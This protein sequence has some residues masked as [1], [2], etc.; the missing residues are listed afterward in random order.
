MPHDAPS[1][2]R[3]MVSRFGIIPGV[4]IPIWFT[5][6]RLITDTAGTLSLILAVSAAPVLI[7]LYLATWWIP[8]RR[9]HWLSSRSTALLLTSWTLGLSFGLTVPDLGEGAA[10]VLV[11]LAGEDVVGISAAISNPS[12]VL[13][14][15]TA[16]LA[17]G[18]CLADTRR[19]RPSGTAQEF[20]DDS[21]LHTFGYTFLH[22]QAS[23]HQENSDPHMRT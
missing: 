2:L 18:F 8:R 21:M 10:S 19:T 7:G 4:G 1:P 3:R 14:T 5:A 22:E 9:G 11:A 20:D 6:G 13:M 17:L 12:G 23:D 15:F 16:A